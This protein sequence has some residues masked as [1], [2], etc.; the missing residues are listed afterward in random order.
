MRPSF[1]PS[2]GGVTMR[3]LKLRGKLLGIVALA[4]A[5]GCVGKGTYEAKEAELAG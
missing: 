1:D 3:T 2:R 5:S 4:V